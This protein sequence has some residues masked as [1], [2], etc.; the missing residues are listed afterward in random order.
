MCNI[1]SVPHLEEINRPP[2]LLIPF[3]RN[4]KVVSIFFAENG[5]EKILCDI[6]RTNFNCANRRKNQ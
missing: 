6:D 3:E 2:W 5:K 1:M 4:C